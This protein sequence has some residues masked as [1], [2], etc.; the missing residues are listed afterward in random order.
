MAASA[1]PHAR[2]GDPLLPSRRA[3]PAGPCN[4]RDAAFGPCG[5]DQFWD[6]SSADLH[7]A[8]EHNRPDSERVPWCVCGHHACF[9]LKVS[10]APAL[11]TL[12]PCDGRCQWLPGA[13]CSLHTTALPFE[14]TQQVEAAHDMF[15]RRANTTP[16]PGP[17]QRLEQ[18][19]ASEAN[20]PGRPVQRPVTPSQ[21]STSGLPGIPSLCRLSH[22]RRP[23][24]DDEARSHVAQARPSGPGLGLSMM[25]LESMGDIDHQ[26]PYSPTVA[27]DSVP[28][29]ATDGVL[30][31]PSPRGHSA[32]AGK[33]FFSPLRG[34]LQH[35]LDF[36]RN[37]QLNP[38]SDTIPDTCEPG[39]YNQSA[40]EVATPSAAA[41]PELCAADRAVQDGKNLLET[42]SQLTSNMPQL[43]GSSNKFASATHAPA[44][45]RLLTNAPSVQQQEQLQNALRSA[46]PQA[47]Q[48]LTS[49]LAPL[50]NLLVSIP[51]VANTMRDLGHRLEVLENGSFNYVQP[52]ELHQTLELYD[53]RL[54]GL[55]YRMDDHEKLHKAIDADNS[56]SRNQRRI[57]AV[58]DS[59][60]SN[61]SLDST[62]SSALILAAMDR[63]GAEAELGDIKERLD[64]L[65]AAAMPTSTN[66]WEIEVVLLPWGRDLRGIWFSLDEPMHDSAK[67]TTQD[68]ED[69]TQVKSPRRGQSLKSPQRSSQRQVRDLDSSPRLGTHTPGRGSVFSD[70]DNGWSGQAISD[71]ASESSDDWLYP[72]ACGSNNL[73][74]KRL[75]SRGFVRNISLKGASSREVQASISHA[76]SDLLEHFKFNSD[77]E[78]PM[79]AAHP[80]L[81]AS[82]IPL[83]K[84]MKDSKLRFLNPSEMANSALWCAQ[85]LAAGVTMRVTGGKKR[86]YVTQREAYMQQSDEEAYLQHHDE[87]GR[88]WTWQELRQLPRYLPD[89][90]RQIEGN[91]EHC[92][93]VSEADA[94]EKCWQYVATYD[95]PPASVT[96]SFES[97]QSTDLPMRRADRQWRRSITPSSILKNRQQQPLSPLSLFHQQRPRIDRNRTASASAVEQLPRSSK[98]RLEASPI[99]QSSAPLHSRAP[100]TSFTRPKRRRVDDSSSPHTEEIM[101]PEAQVTIFH[102]T[103]RRSREPV[104]PFY[105][106]QPALRR[107]DSDITA[108]PSQRS[109]AGF[110]RCTPS[111]YATPHSG[112]YNGGPAYSHDQGGDTEPDDDDDAGSDDGEQ[113]WDPVTDGEEDNMGNSG[114]DAEAGAL[115]QVSFSGDD[116]GFESE[117][118]SDEGYSEEEGIVTSRRHG[119]DNDEDGLK[120]FDDMLS[121]LESEDDCTPRSSRSRTF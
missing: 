10:R 38:P 26:Q 49:Y 103:P 69:W 118:G 100:N 83:R 47:L 19:P 27:D 46:S 64:A 9:H 104:S 37:L 13:E 88:S 120:I 41:T 18:P 35:I 76:F 33:H 85:F 23:V 84:V 28:P 75:L 36:N 4:Y 81:R 17:S 116:S 53:D 44:H 99:K 90:G 110:G 5:C 55:E 95:A 108:R 43:G 117:S 2:L 78:G 22:D 80:G 111:A 106:S 45:Q 40:T 42:L 65:E 67:R 92:P 63:K 77:D 101:Y 58:T 61:H 11:H 72:K 6:K 91:D 12:P 50:H 48:K 79:V 98:R 86:L 114:S 34:P 32:T 119:H 29:P 109:V 94:K 102:P 14:H 57:D 87:V 105:Y 8:S 115:E 62:S 30:E 74:Y 113:S 3:L 21:A 70:T 66:P 25:N 107:S 16:R 52:D 51:N 15:S 54:M 39:F 93:P 121:V 89:R 71:W 56:S 20:E 59:F 24:A 82:F 68:S 7:H 60:A 112:L 96:T 73:V 1:P 97:H 31:K